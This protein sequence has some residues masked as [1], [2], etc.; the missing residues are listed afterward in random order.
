MVAGS[1]LGATMTFAQETTWSTIQ[2]TD[3]ALRFDSETLGAEKGV[4]QSVGLD[5]TSEVVPGSRRRVSTRGAAGGLVAD[6]PALGVLP[7][8]K[9]TL[10]VVLS[11]PTQIATS[12]AYKTIFQ[13]G[14]N[15]GLGLT[16]QEGVPRTDGTRDIYT[17]PGTKINSL[18]LAC[19]VSQLL[20]MTL[21]LRSW[22]E[23]TDVAYASPTYLG[24]ANQ[25][26][27]FLDAT[28]FTL[29][30]TVVN[31]SGVLSVTG[32][33][34]PTSLVNGMSLKID[35]TQAEDRRGFGSAGYI[36]EP[37]EID[38]PPISGS[39]SSEYGAAADFYT[40]FISD[41]GVPFQM[42]FVNPTQIGT[43]GQFPTLDIVIPQ[44]RI[45]TD[46][47]QVGGPG[48]IGQNVTWSVTNDGSNP[49]IQFTVISGEA[50]M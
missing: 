11:G 6:Y 20:K 3:H 26:F 14:S 17:Y 35:R 12:G 18:E 33:A 4:L 1:G 13:L 9:H 42:T 30:G 16:F 19:S 10:G 25:A 49:S 2:T 7:L 31:T 39:F 32:G 22:K 40:P 21:G 23:R 48:L 45:D 36:G 8:L 24:A 28:V 27:S 34:S 43:G 29:G 41:V 37:I 47:T 50:T 46:P 5:G 44:L 38:R 15:R